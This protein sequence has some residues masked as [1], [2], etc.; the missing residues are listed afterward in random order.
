MLSW[1]AVSPEKYADVVAD[2]AASERSR[3]DLEARTI[4]AVAPGE[5]QP[6]VE[7]GLKT[8]KSSSGVTLGRHW[9]DAAGW[10][11]YTLRTQPGVPQEL[12]VTTYGF[13]RGRTYDILV[14]G[15]VLASVAPNTDLRE[16]FVDT[17]YPLPPSF[18]AAAKDGVLTVT[19]AAKP[20]A[21]TASIFGLRLARTPTTP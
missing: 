13:E 14:D 4:D 3:L 19:F 2:L 1:P 10:F 16:R 12:I 21:R 6:E 15:Q 9:R 18:V 11:S 20:D 7:H 8:E 17:T 5:Q